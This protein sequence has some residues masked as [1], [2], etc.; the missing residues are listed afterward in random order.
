MKLTNPT[1][2]RTIALLPTPMKTIVKQCFYVISEMK[3]TSS[4]HVWQISLI[5]AHL[6]WRRLK[7][8]WTR[9]W[10]WVFCIVTLGWSNH[11]SKS[12]GKP[13]DWCQPMRALTCLCIWRLFHLHPLSLNRKAYE[14]L[15]EC[16]WIKKWYL[17][18][19]ANKMSCEWIITQ[20]NWLTVLFSVMYIQKKSNL[21][22]NLIW[23]NIY[24]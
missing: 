23:G 11:Y 15:V 21:R 19:A 4:S 17:S 5:L 13:V 8:H 1:N 9:V 18:M 24:Y 6:I 10:A 2:G 3:I 12:H 16:D 22:A 14:W 20:Q 7:M